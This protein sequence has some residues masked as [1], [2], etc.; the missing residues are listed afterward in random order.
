MVPEL[1]SCN[2]VLNGTA[3]DMKKD[4]KW[5]KQS[6]WFLLWEKIKLNLI[7][8]GFEEKEKNIFLRKQYCFQEI[9]WD[10]VMMFLK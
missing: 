4:D 9:Q 10:L 1:K 8:L 2:E 7:I 6:I 5:P 3:E